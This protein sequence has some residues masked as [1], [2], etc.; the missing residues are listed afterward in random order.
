[1]GYKKGKLLYMVEQN[2]IGAK[3]ALQQTIEEEGEKPASDEV[4]QEEGKDVSLLIE[5]KEK[6]AEYEE[7]DVPIKSVRKAI[8]KMIE[9][10]AK[11]ET[12]QE[13]VAVLSVLLE[14]EDLDYKKAQEILDSGIADLNPEK[15]EEMGIEVKEDGKLKQKFKET[16]DKIKENPDKFIR[17]VNKTMKTIDKA[18]KTLDKA[19]KIFGGFGDA[20]EI[21]EAAKGLADVE[22]GSESYKSSGGERPVD[23]SGRDV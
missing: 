21:G 1:M 15:A 23:P 19:K 8:G 17:D 2:E 16:F 9:E 11:D 18:K 7:I 22:A 12:K 20:S 13:Q 3:Y 6:V 4:Q 5:A 10:N 14:E